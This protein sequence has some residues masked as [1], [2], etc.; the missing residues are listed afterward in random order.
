MEKIQRLLIKKI[1]S[2]ENNTYTKVKGI[3]IVQPGKV[4][5]DNLVS[6]QVHLKGSRTENSDQLFSISTEGRIKGNTN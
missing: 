3:E 2:L 1:K 6:I 5:G 4:Q